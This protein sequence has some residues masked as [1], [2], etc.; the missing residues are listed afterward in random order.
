MFVNASLAGGQTAAGHVR[1]VQSFVMTHR[2]G[3]AHS[4]DTESPG[5]SWVRYETQADMPSYFTGSEGHH[6]TVAGGTIVTRDNTGV[7]FYKCCNAPKYEQLWTWNV[8]GPDANG[9]PTVLVQTASNHQTTQIDAI[10]SPYPCWDGLFCGAQ[11]VDFLPTWTLACSWKLGNYKSDAV[12]QYRDTASDVLG[13]PAIIFE[14]TWTLGPSANALSLNVSKTRIRAGIT[15]GRMFGSVQRPEG[16]TA[17]LTVHAYDCGALPYLTVTINREYIAQSGGHLHLDSNN[18]NPTVFD[19]LDIASPSG[20]TDTSGTFTT[21]V[22]GMNIAGLLKLTATANWS[23]HNLA[24]EPFGVYIGF[25]NLVE[26]TAGPGY[27]LT[28][29]TDAVDCAGGACDNHKYMN[30]FGAPQMQQFLSDMTALYAQLE[31]QPVVLGVNDISLPSG[32]LFDIDGNWTPS[33]WYHRI[34]CG[35][36]IDGSDSNGNPID[37]TDL[38]TVVGQLGGFRVNEGSIHFE[39]KSSV[40]DQILVNAVWPYAAPVRAAQ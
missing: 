15:Y 19:L 17:T 12:Y 28:G 32:G 40:Q 23:G 16:E 35:V 11:S 21:T 1:T 29:S 25:N 39:L 37:E 30:H 6:I 34:G 14:R 24:S 3:A 27:R 38:E 4:L 18:N 20:I 26:I 5:Y 10:G 9:N 22:K 36:D 7:G 31:G 2:P 8:Y 33:H 13:A